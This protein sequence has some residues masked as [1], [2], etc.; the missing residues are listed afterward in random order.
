MSKMV[1]DWF[2]GREVVLAMAIFVNSFPIGVGL[3]MLTLG[4]VSAFAVWQ[5]A[6]GVAALATLIALMAVWA[7]CEPHPNDAQVSGAKTLAAVALGRCE[8]LLVC[9]AGVI[10]GLFNGCFA[11]LF[12]FAASMLGSNGSSASAI[13]GVVVGIATWCVAASVQ[14]GGVLGQRWAKP[15]TLMMTGAIAWS[16][17]LL[18]LAFWERAGAASVILS[19]IFMGLPV[20]TIM[21]LPAE[22]LRPEGRAVGM[23]YFY[24]WLYVGHGALPPVAGLGARRDRPTECPHRLRRGDGPRDARAVWRLPLRHAPGVHSTRNRRHGLSKRSASGGG[25]GVAALGLDR[26]M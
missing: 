24:L 3:A 20:G 1:I 14:G 25:F 11:V 8:L 15:T 9:I 22:V 13:A 2:T 23:G 4:P 10:W 12:G 18:A 5:V 26:R 7:L 6:M 19:G 21:A 16:L 17:C